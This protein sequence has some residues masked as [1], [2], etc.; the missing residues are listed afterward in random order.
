MIFADNLGVFS[1]FRDRSAVG[2]AIKWR[3]KV[4]CL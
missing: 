3:D 1:I 4:D 2:L